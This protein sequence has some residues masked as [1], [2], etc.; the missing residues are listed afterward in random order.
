METAL[1]SYSALTKNDIIEIEYNMIHFELLI[2]E[3]NPDGSGISVIDTDLEVSSNNVHR[4]CAATDILK[5][6]SF[7]F[8]VDFER[9]KG[10][11]T[12]KRA[13]VALP[14]TM[15]DK[16]K[17]DVNEQVSSS[18]APTRPGSVASSK[19]GTAAGS[20]GAESAFESFKGMGSSLNGRRTKGKGKKKET[21]EVDQHRK[22][23]RTE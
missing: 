12:P 10:Y 7:A 4:L 6:S 16:L 14:P 20:L 19:A 2:M 23:F 17:I 15:A 3:T 9:P 8:Q 22:I 11:V 1:R 13:P 5:R 18:G 21:Q